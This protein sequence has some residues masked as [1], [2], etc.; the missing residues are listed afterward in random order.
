M[1]KRLDLI[2][3]EKKLV[4]T[5]SKAQAMI[6]AGQIFVEDK[7]AIKSGELFNYN[8]KIEIKNLGPIWVSRGGIK[9]SHA[10]KKFNIEI[11]NHICMDIGASTGGFTDVLLIF[12]AK[13]M[14][15]MYDLAG[16]D[17]NRRFSP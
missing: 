10:I 14:I 5:R 4:A 15:K 1:K 6:M 17:E 8:S 7:K 9:L 12:G 16:A 2:L 13:K 3:V 11:K